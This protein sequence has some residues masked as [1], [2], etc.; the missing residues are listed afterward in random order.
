MFIVL[1]FNYVPIFGWIYSMYDYVP[2]LSIFDCDFV[3]LEYFKMIFQDA[4]VLR[5]LKNTAI[6]AV[7][8]IV[9]TP[10]PMIFAILLN[11]AR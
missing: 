6:F 10:F 7:I 9:L 4:N 1:L 11:E 8:N 3:G 5:T 2:G